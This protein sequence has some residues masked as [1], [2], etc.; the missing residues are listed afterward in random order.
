MS[1]KQI[2][3]TKKLQ[4]KSH[5]FTN[6]LTDSF[7]IPQKKFVKDAVLGILGSGCIKV[8]KMTKHLENKRCFKTNYERLLRNFKRKGLHEGINEKLVSKQCSKLTSDTFVIMDE[9]DIIKKKAKKMQG[10]AKV[11]DGSTGEIGLGYHL[12]NFTAVIL[13]KR[14][15]EI[16]PIHSELYSNEMEDDTLS[17]VN[18]DRVIDITVQSNNKAT[19]LFDSGS[20]SR[21]KLK[22]FADHDIECIVR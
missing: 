19:W 15:Y 6:S 14:G 2:K 20:D 12:S 7:S 10:I 16:V 9:S 17:T 18:R 8:R 5:H 21:K 3:M 11:R 13:R 1:L 22:F 4:A